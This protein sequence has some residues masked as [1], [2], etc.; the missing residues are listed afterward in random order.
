MAHGLA[1]IRSLEE[2]ESAA[3][4]TVIAPHL[5]TAILAHELR[6]AQQA[7]QIGGRQV[8]IGGGLTH[9]RR[10]RDRH[11]RGRRHGPDW[12]NGRRYGHARRLRTARQ[13]EHHSQKG[14]AP[15]HGA[16]LHI[17]GGTASIIRPQLAQAAR[18]P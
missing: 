15:D 7:T 3:G 17:V 8:E 10:W 12:R 9:R 6:L 18:L 1:A 5:A 11:G 2:E 14:Q 4:R 13:R 16:I